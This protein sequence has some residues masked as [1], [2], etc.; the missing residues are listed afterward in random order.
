MK[1]FAKISL[2]CSLIPLSST[3]AQENRALDVPAITVKKDKKTGELNVPFDFTSSASYVDTKDLENRQTHDINRL[4]R[5]VPGVNITEEDGYGLRPNIGIRGSRSDRSSNITLMEDGVLIAPAPYAAPS[6]YY[7]PS[8]GRVSGIEVR[9][10]SSA[11][12]YGPITTS[13]AVNLLTTPIPQV[14]KGSATLSYGQFNERNVNVNYGNSHDN[15]SY[16]VNFD[17]SASEGFKE[18]PSRDN[19]GYNVQDYMAKFRFNTDKSAKNFQYVEFKLGHNNH[20]SYE[21]YAGLTLGDFVNNP[22][23][24]YAATALDSMDNKHDQFQVTHFVDFDQ[25][26]S[27]KTTAYYN[28]FERSWYKLDKA[29]VNGAGSFTSLSSIYNGSNQ[30]IV[31]VLKGNSLGD[32]QIK[33]NNRQYVSQGVQSALK[34]DFSALGA[35]HEL[36]FGLRIHEDYEDRFQRSDQYQINGS[37]ITLTSVGAA[38]GA[39]NQ[40][41]KANAFATYIEDNMKFGDLTVTPGVRFEKIKLK[42]QSYS[43]AARGA[44]PTIITNEETVFVPGIG[45]SYKLDSDNLVFASVHKGFAP[46]SPG[47]TVTNPE[48]SVNYEIGYRKQG[49]NKLFFES[50]LYAIDY[51]N[52]LGADTASGGGAGTGDQFNG[53]K[54]FSYGAEITS[55]YRFKENVLGKAVKFPVYLSYT[56]NDSEFRSS[57]NSNL[58]EWGNVTKGDKLPYIARHQA[59]LN[60]GAEFDK[61]AINVSTKYVDAMRTTASQGEITKAN[62]IPSHFVTDTSVFFEPTKGRKY[63]VAI[64]NIFD[65]QYAVSAR[66]AGLRPGKPMTARIGIKFDI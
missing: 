60:V 30:A 54:V 50:T 56:F 17:N 47:T 65:R 23:Q 36:E 9:K 27:L 24:R 33:D 10:G 26:L 5:Q 51:D 8:M 18:T 29:R 59:A 53:G 22:Y 41:N 52:L 21:T 6:A 58:T 61:I 28:R 37:Q 12:K 57:F 34:T 43:D 66:P 19:T 25:K 46:P 39:G 45:A 38:G 32:L 55:G 42:R 1:N 13:G 15:F 11:I 40:I 4:V 7:F 35:D 31:E 14:E 20:Q 2:I 48:E 3:F 49:Y 62:K 63:F 44:N 64:D 16:V